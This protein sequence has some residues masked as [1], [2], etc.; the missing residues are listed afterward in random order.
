MDNENTKAEEKKKLKKIDMVSCIFPQT[1][2]YFTELKKNSKSK[3][4][5]LLAV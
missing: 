4:K 1:E 2:N 3:R 5:M